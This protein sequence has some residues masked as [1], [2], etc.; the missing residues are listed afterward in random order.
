MAHNQ[1]RGS[2]V[3]NP[4]TEIVKLSIT[5]QAAHTKEKVCWEGPEACRKA[6]ATGVRRAAF[7]AAC[8]PGD[9]PR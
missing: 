9:F 1:E 6:A 7:P 8:K 3:L 4:R 5:S 2:S